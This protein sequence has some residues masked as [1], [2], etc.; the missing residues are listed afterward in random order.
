MPTQHSYP[1]LRRHHATSPGA[2]LQLESHMLVVKWL[3]IARD[4][5]MQLARNLVKNSFIR[6]YSSA[7][8]QVC[9]AIIVTFNFIT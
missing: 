7:E 9:F 5:D 6:I 8:E 4:F 1:F 3:N 2:N